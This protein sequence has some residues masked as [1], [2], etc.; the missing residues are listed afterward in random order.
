MIVENH[1][2]AISTFL[3]IKS[4]QVVMKLYGLHTRK[5]IEHPYA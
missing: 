5:Q 1:N 4:M 3:S 2:V